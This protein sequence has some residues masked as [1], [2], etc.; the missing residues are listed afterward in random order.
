MVVGTGANGVVRPGNRDW[1]LDHYLSDEIISSHARPGRQDWFAGSG[2]RRRNTTHRRNVGSALGSAADFARRPCAEY[3]CLLVFRLGLCLFATS[4]GWGFSSRRG[5]GITVCGVVQSC[6][7][8]LSGPVRRGHGSREHAGYRD[9]SRSPA[10]HRSHG[11]LVGNL[12]V[13]LFGVER[14]HSGCSFS[15]LRHPQGDSHRT[16]AVSGTLT[17]STSDP[18]IQTVAEKR[19]SKPATRIVV[20][21]ESWITGITVL[22]V[23][24][25]PLRA[26]H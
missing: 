16:L 1:C 4:G 8:A 21:F 26:R 2:D 9:D 15:Y 18:V 12:S 24:E 14:I 5:R 17:R 10:H 3:S 13:Q 6:C 11:G 23:A 19:N 20:Y 22:P 7:C 25:D